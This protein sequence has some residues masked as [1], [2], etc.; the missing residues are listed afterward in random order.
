MV[1][2]DLY[3]VGLFLWTEN[4]NSLCLAVPVYN[5]GVYNVIWEKRLGDDSQGK[6]TKPV[7]I[8]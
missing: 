4:I 3:L 2:K 7:Y 1:E 8:N 5:L 6:A